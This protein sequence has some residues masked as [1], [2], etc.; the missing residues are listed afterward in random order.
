M[1]KH[2]VTDS[3]RRSGSGT[4]SGCLIPVLVSLSCGIAVAVLLAATWNDCGRA[5]PGLN[6]ALA[7]FYGLIATVVTGVV[8]WRAGKRLYLDDP[9]RPNLAACLMVA[10][11]VV[12]VLYLILVPLSFSGP[13][14]QNNGAGRC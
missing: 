8:F 5:A 11:V 12:L 4:A 7:M 1:T 13:F 9:P 3:E 10:V 6:D 2:L 14:F